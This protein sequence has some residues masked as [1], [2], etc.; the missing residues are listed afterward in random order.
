MQTGDVAEQIIEAVAGYASGGVEVDT[1]ER[2]HNFRMVRY[3]ERGRDGFPETLHFHVVTVVGAERYG[4]VN[5]LRNEKHFLPEFAF[6]FGFPGLQLFEAFGLRRDLLFDF[7]RLLFF[8]RVFL[9]LSHELSDFLTQTVT[10]GTELIGLRDDSTAFGVER[11]N[12]IHEGEFG[13][14]KL[15]PDILP[16]GVGVLP[17]KTNVKH[18][19]SSFLSITAGCFT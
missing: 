14:L 13:V 7:L 16:H 5:H 6:Q 19:D 9:G 17:D 10:V 4:R 11:E 18:M 3:R 15:F 12:L 8:G 2:I 1:V